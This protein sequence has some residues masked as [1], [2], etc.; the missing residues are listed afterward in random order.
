MMIK[1]IISTEKAPAALGPYSQAVVA[2]EFVFCTG[3]VAVDPAS[4]K[5]IDGG[6]EEQTGKVLDNLKAVLEA[7]GSGLEHV[8][9]TT[10][11]LGDMDDF[12][13]MNGVY[14]RYFS[15]DQPARAAFQVARLPLGAAIEIECVALLK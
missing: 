4:G 13:A 14:S 2:G 7:A 6:I 8:V 10:V 1:Q 5:L 3:Q 15:S 9:K 11:L 12:A